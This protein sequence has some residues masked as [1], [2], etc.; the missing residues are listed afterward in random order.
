MP[1]KLLWK[2]FNTDNELYQLIVEQSPSTLAGI[3]INRFYNR[4]DETNITAIADG[5]T[6]ANDETYT[7]AGAS[8][9]SNLQHHGQL[10]HEIVDI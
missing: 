1:P 10:W 4:A 7:D 2:N 6:P 3:R 5:L 9:R 8:G